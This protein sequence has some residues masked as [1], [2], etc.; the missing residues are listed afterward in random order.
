MNKLRF[1]SVVFGLLGACAAAAGIWLALNNRDASPVLVE[2]PAAAENQVVTMLDALCA[3]DYDT[4]SATLYG[5]PE[6]GLNRTA[7]DPVGEL[8]WGAFAD[9]VTY[10]LDEEFYITDSGV[11]RNVVITGLELES[12]TENLRERSQTLLEQRVAQAEDTSEIYDENNE[13][14]EEFVMAVLYDAAQDALREDARTTVWELPLN[15]I[16]ENGQWWIML[17]SA[18]LEAISGGILG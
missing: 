17:E 4:V 8:M 15:L 1:F 5:T 9:S 7:K 16:Y 2:Q 14:K 12:L 11:A 18:L 10:E 3:R 6:L 13:Y